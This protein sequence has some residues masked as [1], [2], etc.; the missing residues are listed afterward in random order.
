[1]ESRYFIVTFSFSAESGNGFGSSKTITTGGNYLNEKK[2]I[3]SI[4]EDY[5]E[6]KFNSVIIL[7]IIELSE[8]DFNQYKS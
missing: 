8:Q 6:Y 7:N 1:M 5:K 2:F 4:K 3:E